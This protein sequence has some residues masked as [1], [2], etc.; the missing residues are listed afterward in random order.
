MFGVSVT[1]VHRCVKTFCEAMYKQRKDVIK[2][3]TDD[4]AAIIADNFEQKY[5]YPQAFGAIDGSH[6]AITPPSDGYRDFINRKMYPSI[7]LQAVCDDKYIFRDI[8]AQLPGCCHD[9]NVFSRSPLFEK[10]GRLP[11]RN[12]QILGQE[13]PL[14]IVGDPAYP[15]SE[16][17][18]KGYTGRNLAPE[19]ESLVQ[20]YF[21]QVL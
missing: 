21:M 13:V 11:Q 6:I 2:W 4:E 8:F 10:M 20:Y 19:C 5:S 1:S 14:H 12:R 9:A 15:L 3:P 7:V 17:L 16:G 18:I